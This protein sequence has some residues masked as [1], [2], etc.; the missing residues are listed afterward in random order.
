M[1]KNETANSRLSS[2]RHAIKPINE[3][4]NLLKEGKKEILAAAHFLKEFFSGN[5]Y[6]QISWQNVFHESV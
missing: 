3:E 1:R 2:L 5:F 6:Y 4:K